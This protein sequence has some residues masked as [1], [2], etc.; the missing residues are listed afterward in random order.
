ML[1]EKEELRRFKYRLQ[2]VV[3]DLTRTAELFHQFT[4]PNFSRET[5]FVS[6]KGKG[7]YPSSAAILSR[8]RHSEKRE[9]VPAHDK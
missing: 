4:L 7:D 3:D 2:D 1:P 6:L 5:E 8:R 9:R